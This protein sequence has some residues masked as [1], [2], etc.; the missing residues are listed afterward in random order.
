MR[1]LAVVT[2]LLLIGAFVFYSYGRTAYETAEHRVLVD[3]SPFQLREYST[4]QLVTTPMERGDAEQDGSSFGRLFRYIS[5]DNESGQ[6]ISMTTPVFMSGEGDTGRMSFVVPRE[7]AANGAPAATHPDIE[8]ETM[9][10]GRFAAIR[11]SG[12]AT[13]EAL[14][15][16]RRQLE[17]WI[18][19][20]GWQRTG[21]AIVAGYD[22]PFIPP[23]FRRNEVLYRI[24]D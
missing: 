17:N 10:P 11:F 22:P 4:L 7:V 21:S 2:L 18:D 1:T 13:P 6:A 5:G 8:L 14:S 9:A 19:E 3:T 12:R 24:K 16:A 23:P 15:A 20:R